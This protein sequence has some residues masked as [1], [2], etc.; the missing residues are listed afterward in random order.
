MPIYEYQCEKC[1]KVF[2]VYAEPTVNYSACDKSDCLN[3]G[4]HKW[5]QINGFPE[6]HFRG[7]YCCETCSAEKTVEEELATK[8][9]Y[10]EYFNEL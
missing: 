7:K 6:I 3:G 2:E 8:Q 9:E 4:E 5:K 1:E 10:D